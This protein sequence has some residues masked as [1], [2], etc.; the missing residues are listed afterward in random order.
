MVPNLKP[1]CVLLCALAVVRLAGAQVPTLSI[2]LVSPATLEFSW[3]SNFT[4]ANWQLMSATSLGSGNWQPV[5]QS[6]FTSNG[7]VVVFYSITNAGSYFR[8]QQQITGSGCIFQAVPP[9]INAGGSSTLTWCPEA[10]VTYYISPG[11]MVVPGGSL[12]VNPPSTTVYTLTASNATSVTTTNVAVIVNPC[13]WLQI[14]NIEATVTFSYALAP[15][16]KDFT[17]N[18]NHQASVT[19]QL[20]QQVGGTP[21][22]AYYFGFAT[23]GTASI[24]DLEV[25]HSGPITFTTTE[26][27]SG[28]PML[29]VSYISLHVTCTDYDFSYSVV[30]PS[31]ETSD[32]GTT[33][34]SDGAGY[35][36]MAP[37]PLSLVTDEISDSAQVP[38]E[39]PPGTPDYYVPDSDLGK[40]MFN[41]GVVNN[42]TAGNASVSWTFTP[43][44]F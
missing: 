16:N 29:N 15:A 41:N 18:I 4:A 7:A 2:S 37:R 1:V 23:G 24:N 36:A 5:P 6:P 27:G 25:N 22:D 20:M 32:F 39:Y 10:G 44:P 8:L 38:A 33:T 14:S 19:F 12:V 17:Y 11:S 40:H 34:S 26:V 21:T 13:G 31:V 43:E 9:V 28:L 3:P 42:S 35:G 30:V